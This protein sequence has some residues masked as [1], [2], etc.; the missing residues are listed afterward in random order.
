MKLKL[1]K[2][3]K[4]WILLALGAV[5]VVGIGYSLANPKP[6]DAFIVDIAKKGDIIQTVEVTGEVEP[7]RAVNLAFSTSGRVG[8]VLVNVG[9]SV[10]AGQTLMTLEAGDLAAELSRAQAILNKEN[11]GATQ[12]AIAIAQASVA[13]SEANLA[14]AQV[15][16]DTALENETKIISALKAATE[17]SLAALNSAKNDQSFGTTSQSL[18]VSQATTDLVESLKSG[19]I[20]VRSGLS[21]ADQVLGIENQLQNVDFEDEL[22]VLDPSALQDAT[23]YFGYAAESRDAAEDAIVALSTTSSNEAILSAYNLLKEAITDAGNTLLYTR[24]VL[25]ATAADSYYFSLDDLNSL[26]TT[27]DSARTSVQSASD[28]VSV[29]FQAYDTTVTNQSGT[30]QSNTDRVTEAQAAY[31]LALANEVKDTATAKSQVSSSLS[32]LKVASANLISAKASL[33]E[34]L[35]DPRAVDLASLQ[36]DI[37]AAQAR[38]S[39]ALIVSPLDGIVTA[40]EFEAG[41]EAG[42][43]SLAVAVQTNDTNAFD[44]PI[45]IPESDIAKVAIGNRAT[46]T[47]DA[48]GD[49]LEFEGEV[50]FINPAQKEIE[51]VIFYEATIVFKSGQDLA[52]VKSGMSADVTVL[53]QSRFGVIYV[54]QR[55]I[56]EKDGQKYVR[57]PSDDNQTF[58]EHPVKTGLKADDGWL[59]IT[60]GLSEGDRIVL[61]VKK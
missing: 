12:E 20:A 4:T 5:L 11:T 21:D 3:K 13:V 54:P 6:V 47:F 10:K 32:A 46:I 2:S 59:E 36:A 39:K 16:Y 23:R 44:I 24:R 34:V 61:S 57:L 30:L 25:D 48:F 45:D 26:K 1:P 31:D 43:G 38:Y 50:S 22:S 9:D 40:V 53:T 28:S 58:T 41:E 19:V 33:A 15:D 18:S 27:I 14:A 7:Q 49:D 51:G 42:A 60:E 17:Q 37:A 35:A 55:S 29:A 8:Q 56:L 52:A